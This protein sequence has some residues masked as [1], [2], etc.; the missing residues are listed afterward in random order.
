MSESV[1]GIE[2]RFSDLKLYERR[3]MN[4]AQPLPE[5]AMPSRGLLC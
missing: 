2:R 5:H 3:P 1:A 4:R